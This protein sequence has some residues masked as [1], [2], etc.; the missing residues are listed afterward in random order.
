[1][2]AERTPITN[3]PEFHYSIDPTAWVVSMY[4]QEKSQSSIDETPEMSI[5]KGYHSALGYL[6]S[7][8]LRSNHP[9]IVEARDKLTEIVERQLFIEALSTAN[10]LRLDNTYATCG[11]N[12][13]IN[14][15]ELGDLSISIPHPD[16][17]H[18]EINLNISKQQ[19]SIKVTR[20]NPQT[21]YDSAETK[22]L[23][24]E[25]AGRV[26]YVLRTIESDIEDHNKFLHQLFGTNNVSYDLQTSSSAQEKII[27]VKP[28]DTNSSS[29]LKIKLYTDLGYE[30]SYYK[31]GILVDGLIGEISLRE[32]LNPAYILNTVLQKTSEQ[33]GQDS[34]ANKVANKE[35]NSTTKTQDF[36]KEHIQPIIIDKI[37]PKLFNTDYSRLTY[38][39]SGY[40]ITT[41][42]TD[43]E[44]S[45]EIRMT[46]R[47]VLHKISYRTDGEKIFDI[48][49]AEISGTTN[50]LL[51]IDN[52]TTDS[53]IEDLVAKFNLAICQEP[54][55]KEYFSQAKNI[56]KKLFSDDFDKPRRLHTDRQSNDSGTSM[57]H[58]EQIE[59]CIN[60]YIQNGKRRITIHVNSSQDYLEA[61]KSTSRRN[62]LYSVN[63][64]FLSGKSSKN[65]AFRQIVQIHQ[66]IYEIK[67]LEE[68]G[69]ISSF[70]FSTQHC[71]S[72]P[73]MQNIWEIVKHLDVCHQK[74]L[75][76]RN[77]KLSATAA[78]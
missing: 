43:H 13:Q 11:T 61:I 73:D 54:E 9:S 7:F 36:I 32:F 27:V 47:E 14:K 70:K 64:M 51:N 31:N 15:N 45:V 68:N 40:S 39:A 42:K 17:Q 50:R 78:D 60:K 10:K 77:T 38:N 30:S 52:K 37:L 71:P 20:T 21:E 5:S 25:A 26:F 46:D 29:L 19:Q 49:N 2:S 6:D 55:T 65:R 4:S 72:Y 53:S 28:N 3:L 69:E 35:N 75:D 16:R 67:K 62:E 74:A 56:L 41:A 18:S 44:Y 66:N 59:Y 22:R 23:P 34:I 48:A 1:M 24:L 57:E 76:E 63:P 12:T 58:V 8:S 33:S